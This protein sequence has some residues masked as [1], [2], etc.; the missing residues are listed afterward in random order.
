VQQGAFLC[1][2]LLCGPFANSPFTLK[3][4]PTYELQLAR[5]KTLWRLKAQHADSIAQKGKRA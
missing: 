5:Q 3:L 4:R 1:A 2:V